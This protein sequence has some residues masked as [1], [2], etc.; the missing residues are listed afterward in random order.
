MPSL[1]R[2][3]KRLFGHENGPNANYWNAKYATDEFIYTKVANRFVVEYLESL[4]AGVMIDVAGGE[5]RN[6]VWFAERGWNAEV[7]DFADK[8]V[9]KFLKFAA[10]R[11]VADKCVGTVADATTFR[12]KTAPADLGV[13]GYL[14]VPQ[15]T[16]EKAIANVVKQ[17]KPGATFFGV[18]HARENLD[19]GYGGPQDPLVLPTVASLTEILSKL[20]VTIQAIENR[21]GQ[22]QTREGLK[23]SVTVIAKA[24][25]N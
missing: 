9:A 19:G 25:V 15:P 2:I 18:W 1:R 23:P 7:V 10:E 13:V 14:Q 4:P 21:D 6:A 20:P 12:A 17:L 8:A 24:I 22:V 3:V 16:L 11:G 5:G